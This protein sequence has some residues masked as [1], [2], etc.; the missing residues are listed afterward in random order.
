[1]LYII[2]Q[3]GELWCMDPLGRQSTEWCKKWNAFFVRCL[4]EGSEINL[5]WLQVCPID[6]HFLNFV[7]FG[8]GATRNHIDL[9]NF[10]WCVCK[11]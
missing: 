2:T 4:I 8:P 11:T 10:R 6:T 9:Q 1:L 7:N 3:I 5:A